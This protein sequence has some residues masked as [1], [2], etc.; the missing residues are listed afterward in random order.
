MRALP[1]RR[2]R[3][4]GLLAAAA[5]L[6]MSPAASAKTH[7]SGGGGGTTTTAGTGFDVSY[8]QCPGTSLPVPISFGIVGVNQGIVYS[9]NT[10][11]AAEYAWALNN[12][13]STTH[14]HVS[15]YAN[16]A[17][18]GPSSGHWRTG[19]T[20]PQPCPSDVSS[21]GCDY[22]YGWYAAQD[23]YQDAVAASSAGVAQ[24]SP[25]W[26]DVESANSWVDGPT[27]N[28]ADLQG[29][30]DF[31]STVVG[32]KAGIYTNSYTWTTYFASTNAFSAYPAWLPGASTL[33]G[34]ESNCKAVAPTTGQ[35]T[36]TQ[37]SA[38]GLDADYPCV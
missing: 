34:A 28:A 27:N 7:K 30:L 11:A 6:A 20:Y 33:T 14:P 9:P 29:A 19:S 18:P 24:S 36:L 13:T 35:V 17:D 15:F 38:D 32:L 5:V 25:W 12:S 4:A 22:D 8:P 21:Y 26:L 16:T 3:L 23:S 1:T 31:F 10:C 2:V 37:Y